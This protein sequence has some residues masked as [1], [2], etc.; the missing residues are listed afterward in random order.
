MT[1]IALFGSYLG[2]QLLV[3][4]IVQIFLT[5]AIPPIMRASGV[6]GILFYVIPYAVMLG[7][8]FIFGV[9]VVV[10]LGYHPKPKSHVVLNI[11]E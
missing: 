5:F 1:C 3:A 11:N 2:V 9:L 7:I 10:Y 8:T 6:Q 4:G